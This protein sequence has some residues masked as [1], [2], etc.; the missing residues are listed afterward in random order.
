LGQSDKISCASQ[1]RVQFEQNLD[2]KLGDPQFNADITPLLAEGYEWNAVKAA[3]RVR[4]D[5]FQLL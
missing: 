1:P 3:K 5:L 2:S 4:S